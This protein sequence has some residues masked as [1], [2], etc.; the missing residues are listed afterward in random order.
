MQQYVLWRNYLPNVQPYYAVKCNPDPILLQ[1]MYM[2]GISFDCAS[3]YEMTLVKNQ[4]RNEH[5]KKH[6]LLANPCK[7][8]NDILTG[9][10][11]NVPWVT[12]D[13]KEELVKMH[14]ADYRPKV[15]LRIAVD[16]SSSTCPFNVKFGL[17]EEDVKEVAYLAKQLNM[18]LT[19]LSFHVGSGSTSPKAFQTAID[20][21][22]S[23]WGDLQAKQ[24]VDTFETL[25]I[26]GGW[27]SKEEEF[28]QQAHYANIGL[29]STLKSNPNSIIAEPGRFFA[30]NTHDLYVKVVGKKPRAGGGWRYTIDESVYGQFSCIPFDHA[31]PQ[32]ARVYFTEG[33]K[34]RP[35]TP[36]TIF[37]R[38]CDSLDWICNSNEMDELEVGD[39]LYIPNMG[40]YTTATATEFNGFPKPQL[41]ESNERPMS[42][43]WLENVSYPL[44]SMLS[45]KKNESKELV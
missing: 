36:A 31:N 40:A 37:G 10:L 27:S 21:A 17:F 23:I 7:T 5:L 33:D 18:P 20:M 16:D 11:Y 3:A 13:S 43:S 15:L 42:I 39:W 32:I 6:I 35:K 41:I 22:R 12:A 4:F 1:W 38:T 19:G 8:P 29:Q 26:G 30:A 34:I 25:D 2:F 28:I 44:A 24:Y 45:V 9:K 14:E